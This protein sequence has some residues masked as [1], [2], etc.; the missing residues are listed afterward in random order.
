MFETSLSVCDFIHYNLRSSDTYNGADLRNQF[1]T[2]FSAHFVKRD[3]ILSLQGLSLESVLLEML[4][5]N[6]QITELVLQADALSARY[7]KPFFFLAQQMCRV[8]LL[9]SHLLHHLFQLFYVLNELELPI[10]QLFIL[11]IQHLILAS[12]VVHLF[13]H[14]SYLTQRVL[15][16]LG[17]IIGYSILHHLRYLLTALE[18]LLQFK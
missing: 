2:V 9:S 16:S 4:E 11:P 15:S 3:K 17:Y 7:L 13:L 6:L 12:Q 1:A 18:V 8:L 5:L 14:C 10:E